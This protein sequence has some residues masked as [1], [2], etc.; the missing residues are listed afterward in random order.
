MVVN[1]AQEPDIVNLARNLVHIQK[2]HD[3]VIRE[4]L[5]WTAETIALD[6]GAI[7]GPVV[8]ALFG[9]EQ[10]QKLAFL[11][12]MRIALVCNALISK[13][14][15]Q[16]LRPQSRH[17]HNQGIQI[18]RATYSDAKICMRYHGRAI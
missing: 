5:E 12:A 2:A 8:L 10:R 18:Q 6:L 16:N 4:Q 1:V 3:V 13:F 14:L 9:A 11:V 7:A 15:F 17:G